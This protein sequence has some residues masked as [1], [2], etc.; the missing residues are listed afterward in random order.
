MVMKKTQNKHLFR[1][2]KKNGVS[3]FAVAF[4]AAT[5]IAIFLGIQEAAYSILEGAENFFKEQKLATWEVTCQNGITQND[6]GEISKWED[7]DKA[8]GGYSAMVLAE[9]ETEKLT[10]NAVSIGEDINIPVVLEGTLPVFINEVAVEQTYAQNENLKVGDSLKLLHDGCLLEEE[11]TITAIVNMPVYNCVSVNDAR[12][13]SDEGFGSASYYVQLLTEAFNPQYY[14][15][16]YTVAYLLNEELCD[17]D[18]YDD[19]YTKLEE[20]LEL[21]LEEKGKERAEARYEE[22]KDIP[23]VSLQEWNF[24]GRNDIGDV[25]GIRTEVDALFKLSYSLALIFLIVAIVVCYAAIMRMI[26]EQKSLIGA[27]KAQGFTSQSIMFHYMKY[28]FLCALLGILIGWLASVVIVQILILYIFGDDFVMNNYCL[29][30]TWPEGLLVALLFFVIFL[31]ATYIAC[32]KMV[33]LSAIDLLRG[34]VPGQSREYFFEKWKAYKNLKLYSRLVIKNVL[35][36]KERMLTTIMGV[37]GCIA[38][39]VICFSLKLSIV[40]APVKQFEDYFLY[41]NRLA[42]D[43]SKGTKEAFEEILDEEGISYLCIQDKLKTFRLPDGEWEN[44]HVLTSDDAEKLKEYMVLEDAHTKEIQKLPDDGIYVSKRCAEKMNLSEGDIVEIMDAKGNTKEFKIGGIISHYL[45]YHLFITSESYYETAMEEEAD[46]CIFLLKG[47]IDGLLEKVSKAEGYL[48]LKDNSEYMATASSID[49][50]IAICLTL[51]AVIAVL[52]LL[53]QVTMHINKKARELSVMRINGY[54]MK[55]TKAFVY[56][57]NIVLTILGLI[58]GGGIGMALAYVEI[59]IIET[60]ANSYIRMPSI[61]AALL[62]C[63][64]GAVFALIVNIIGLRKIN[65]LNLTNVSSN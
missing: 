61:Y 50:V 57:D 58:L 16:C 54:T 62:A 15:N 17:I 20:E 23:G 10:V 63:A 21:R 8:E 13:K 64:I 51:S 44:V 2:I 28:S 14:N 1:T 48:S 47:N 37:V 30:F 42:I 45:P 24:L 34:E 27:Q 43:S 5:S 38:L 22:L 52:V 18:Y 46:E 29:T 7:V 59:R 26:N 49:L 53:N 9:G 4:I 65:H 35:G 36:D 25:R 6:I 40:N 39:L 3:F 33:K 12:G 56:K 32:K 19:A 55:E 11:F 60:G 41:E 31:T